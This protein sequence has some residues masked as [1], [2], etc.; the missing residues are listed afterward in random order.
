MTLRP[1]VL[2][3]HVLALDIPAFSETLTERGYLT[4]APR[5]R[6]TVEKSDNWRGRLDSAGVKWPREPSGTEHNNHLA[7]SHSITSSARARS[8]GGIVKPRAG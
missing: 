7:P 4:F 6:A 1:T 2:D 8:K 5:K 3:Q